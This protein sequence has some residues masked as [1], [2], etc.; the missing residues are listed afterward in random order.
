MLQDSLGGNTKTV[1]IAN[2]GPVDYNYDET[3]STLRYAYRAK[4]IQNKPR[5]NEDP[6]DA[7]IRE[8]QEEINRL[9]AELANK[10]PGEENSAQ[11]VEERIVEKVVEVE[12]EIIVDTGVSFDD[13]KAIEARMQREKE[14]IKS[15]LER[16]KKKLTEQKGIADAEREDLLRKLEGKQKAAEEKDEEQ[17]EIL[18]K[19]KAMEAKMLVGSQV[20]EKALAQEM[21]LR[22]QQAELIERERAEK[23][24]EEMVKREEDEKLGLEER[25]S[26]IEDQVQKLKQKLEKLWGR[27][28]TATNEIQE[29]Q[30]ECQREREDVLDTIRE[31]QKEAKLKSMVIERLIPADEKFRIESRA[32]WDEELNKPTV[33]KLHLAGNNQRKNLKQSNKSHLEDQEW[34]EAASFLPNVYYVYTDDGG[35]ARAEDKPQKKRAKDKRQVVRP[36]TASRKGRSNKIQSVHEDPYLVQKVDET[37]QMELF[38]KA[39]GLVRS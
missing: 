21:E 16:D 11:E 39:R 24:M 28:K 35:V 1:M 32:A 30:Q 18:S 2:V 27:Y 34:A 26:S 6:K 37:E 3:M 29:L 7:M 19:V 23:R 8:F 12:K 9:K 22:R 4:S 20:M 13:L 15:K 36:N 31:F 10:N 17:A 5:I 25:F 33:H 14:S 38:P